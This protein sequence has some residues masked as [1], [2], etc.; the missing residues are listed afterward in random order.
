[1]TWWW[2]VSAWLPV[3]PCWALWLR[4]KRWL[5]SENHAHALALREATLAEKH[6]GLD[7]HRLKLAEVQAKTDLARIE[8]AGNLLPSYNQDRIPA[9]QRDRALAILEA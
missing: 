4:H 8:A 9:E 7:E 5:A 2:L 3:L 1:M 6:I